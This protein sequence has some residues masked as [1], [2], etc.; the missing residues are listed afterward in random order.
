MSFTRHCR[1][2][3]SELAGLL[4]VNIEQ[5]DLREVKSDSNDR[6]P[7][8]STMIRTSTMITFDLLPTPPGSQGSH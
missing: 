7:Y 4:S 2:L 5:R 1:C 8:F 6:H 3:F